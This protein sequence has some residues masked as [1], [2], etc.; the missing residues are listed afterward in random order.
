[1]PQF[2]IYLTALESRLLHH[3]AANPSDWIDNLVEWRVRIAEDD[4]LPQAIEKLIA[5]GATHIPGTRDEI[6]LASDMP[7]KD[8][9]WTPIERDIP[10]DDKTDLYTFDLEEDDIKMLAW[11]YENPHEHI[12]QWV[13]E[14][15]Q[16]AIKEKADMIRKELLADPLWTDPIPLDPVALLD[17]VQLRT[18]KDHLDITTI[19]A[20]NLVKM[21][22]EDP[23]WIPE[24][25]PF[26]R[27]KHHD[28]IDPFPPASAGPDAP[29]TGGGP[30]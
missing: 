22:A 8:P 23:S 17:L 21:T 14:R 12:Q 10:D 24:S 30:R 1:M 15:C 9:N 27:F 29:P 19:H 11:M 20:Q 3:T 13:V 26:H 5:A 2:S 7:P 6:I 16:I 28:H 25:T 4:Y 18:V